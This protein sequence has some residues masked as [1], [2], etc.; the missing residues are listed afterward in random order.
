[1]NLSQDSAITDPV[2]LRVTAIISQLN[3]LAGGSPTRIDGPTEDWSLR[4]LA[5]ALKAVADSG[6]SFSDGK[7]VSLKTVLR[8]LQ[9]FNAQPYRLL[10]AAL[11]Q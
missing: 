11:A 7:G 9:T 10:R 1:M 3:L 4:E 2:A 5:D 6:F 8:A